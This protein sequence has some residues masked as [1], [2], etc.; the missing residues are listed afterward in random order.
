MTWNELWEFAAHL[1]PES[2]VTFREIQS[3]PQ[4]PDV[5]VPMPPNISLAKQGYTVEYLN[6]GW[7]TWPL[8]RKDSSY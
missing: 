4:L 6:K 5:S 2:K 7:Q 3:A 8:R 1:Y